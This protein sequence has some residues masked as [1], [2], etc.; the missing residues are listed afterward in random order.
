MI[1]SSSS[2]KARFLTDGLAYLLNS[3]HFINFEMDLV[4]GQSILL[5]EGNFC[6]AF[7]GDANR[8]SRF[9]SR[10]KQT[11]C[12]GDSIGERPLFVERI[13]E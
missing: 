11:A 4:E 12:P 10:L 9:R 13:V 5:R 3:R 6:D 1:C 2:G 7:A 8:E